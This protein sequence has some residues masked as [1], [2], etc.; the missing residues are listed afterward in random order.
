MQAK[1]LGGL[2]HNNE[3]HIP[4]TAEPPEASPE[5]VLPVSR[6]QEEDFH[7]EVRPGVGSSGDDS[8]PGEERGYL[9]WRE[10][11][12]IT[13][14]DKRR[15]FHDTRANGETIRWIG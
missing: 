6:M 9:F 13:E 7:E 2:Y 8:F 10:L 15:T 3:T 1:Q 5:S 12:Y 14:A 4:P 11:R